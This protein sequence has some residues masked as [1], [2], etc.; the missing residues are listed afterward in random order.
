M[1]R[2]HFVFGVGPGAAKKKVKQVIPTNVIH[3]KKAKGAK[4]SPRWSLL[5]ISPPSKQGWGGKSPKKITNKQFSNFFFVRSRNPTL[6]P[7]KWK[8][9][10]SC[11]EEVTK[12]SVQMMSTRGGRRKPGKTAPQQAMAGGTILRSWQQCVLVYV[13][14][15]E[16]RG[17]TG[18][19]RLIN[20]WHVDTFHF[21]RL[22]VLFFPCQGP[23]QHNKKIGPRRHVAGQ[24]GSPWIQDGDDHCKRPLHWQ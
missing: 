8:K 1:L 18:F 15:E 14:G 22:V 2:H 11:L 19:S 7:R 9:V 10:L 12:L 21:S 16:I 13:V 24:H 23:G 17:Q 4:V 6:L 20:S 3:R 5:R